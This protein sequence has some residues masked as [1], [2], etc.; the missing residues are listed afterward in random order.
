MPALEH[1][2]TGRKG[3]GS[4]AQFAP[5]LPTGEGVNKCEAMARA[6]ADR[7]S[8]KCAQISL[9]TG[10]FEFPWRSQRAKA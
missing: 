9:E 6:G 8:A 2:R 3:R 7:Q 5:P 4:T 10:A 1:V